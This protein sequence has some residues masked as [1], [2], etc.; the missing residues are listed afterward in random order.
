MLS[1]TRSFWPLNYI[2][3]ISELQVASFFLDFVF[4][5]L[6]ISIWPLD[7]KTWS[8]P[9]LIH[10]C[11]LSLDSTSLLFTFLE[12]E[13]RLRNLTQQTT[14]AYCTTNHNILLQMIWYAACSP[15]LFYWYLNKIRI[16]ISRMGRIQRAFLQYTKIGPNLIWKE[17][18][19]VVSN[20]FEI[21]KT[22]MQFYSPQKHNFWGL[23]VFNF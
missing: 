11:S 1:T 5:V 10:S 13:G 14:K 4:E 18:K 15:F 9:S 20:F 2:H 8:F 19:R 23:C 12:M 6:I 7:T 17:T 16:S 3:D 22:K 21:W